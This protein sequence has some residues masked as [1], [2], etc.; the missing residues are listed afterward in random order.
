MRVPLVFLLL[1]TSALAQPSLQQQLRSIA[2]AAHGKLSVACA[3]PGT[4]LDCDLNPDAHPPMQSVFKLPLAV[5]VL[6]QVEQ[7]K[8]SL[9]QPVRFRP[10]DRFVPNAYSPLQDKYPEAKVDV[11]LRELL[12]LTVSF[13]DNAAADILV[14]VA[15][16]PSTV[17]QYIGSLGVAGFHLQ[18][19]EHALHRETQ[20]QYRNWFAPK[21]AV[22]LLR[23]LSDHS[24]LSP[25]HTA[26]L[27]EWMRDSVQTTRLRGDLPPG[28][29]VAH[30]SGTSGVEHGA[31]AA[32]NDIGLIALPD[33][34][35]LA[36]AVFVTDATADDDTRDKVIARI[37]RAVY[38]AA[39]RKP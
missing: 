37:G 30:R 6:H 4:S 5:T 32:T 25:E 28:V 20:L 3:L 2:A 21:G 27:L 17:T 8:L 9:D 38:D 1:T 35:Q 26:M 22:E 19:D 12:R 18:D 29:A 31:A 14:R 10:E 13:S 15:G 16:G 33:G 23:A 24:P 34:R 39:I 36:I 11:S 7:G